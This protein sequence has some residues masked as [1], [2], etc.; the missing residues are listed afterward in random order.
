VLRRRTERK[1]EGLLGDQSGLRGGRG[2]R[3]AIRML[4]IMSERTLDIDEELCAGHM[5]WQNSFDRVKWTKL[6]QI[7]KGNGIDWR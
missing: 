4:R 2:S 1:I 3:D 5:D 7:V 6:M